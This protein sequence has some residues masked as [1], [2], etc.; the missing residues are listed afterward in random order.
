MITHMPDPAGRK[1]TV[2]CDSLHLEVGEWPEATMFCGGLGI[3]LGLY[4]QSREV[5]VTM[6]D[7][8]EHAKHA[9]PANLALANSSDLVGEYLSDVA[10]S[11][12]TSIRVA[13]DASWFL[14]TSLRQQQQANSRTNL[15]SSGALEAKVV[16]D[17][18]QSHSSPYPI[19]FQCAFE[20][21]KLSLSATF[22]EGSHG[23]KFVQRLLGQISHVTSQL[24]L[25]NTVLRDLN[26]L[27]SEDEQDIR[28]WT[29]APALMSPSCV[30]LLVDKQ[31]VKS[32]NAAAVHAWDGKLTYGELDELSS[33][34]AVQ[35]LAAKAPRR[36]VIPLLLEKSMWTVVA[37][38]AVLKSGHAFLL[39]DASHPTG[40]LE[41]LIHDIKG[42][43]IMASQ[44]QKDRASL[45]VSRV[46][47]VSSTTV[48]RDT[49]VSPWDPV[50]AVTGPNDLALVVYT[51]GTT[52]RPKATAIEHHSICSGLM[53]LAEL[54]GISETCRYYQFSSY[55]WDAAFGEILMTLFSGGCVCIPS[56][57]DRINRLA[58]SMNLLNANSVLLTPTVLRLLSPEEI[59]NMKNIIMG[60]E[61]VTRGL[62]R[63]WAGHAS[64][65]TVY[66]PAECTVACM[67]NQQF[68]EEFDPALIG[69]S[70]GCR[71]WITLA[72]DIN[73]LAPVGVAGELLIEGS[74][75]ARGYLNDSEKTAK[76]FLT[77]PPAWMTKMGLNRL[78]NS[79]FYRT[80]DLARYTTDG[81]LIFVGR[82]DF[83]VKL[84]GQRIE[85]EEIQSQI[86]RLLGL[87]GAQVF[88]DVV[89]V[90]GDQQLPSLAAFIHLPEYQNEAHDGDSL[91]EH[92]TSECERLRVTLSEVLPEFMVP[93]VWIPLPSIPL[94]SSGKL[95]RR[96]LL[97]LGN[98]Y[99]SDLQSAPRETDELNDMQQRL[100]QLWAQI[101]STRRPGLTDN[102][103]SLG[104]DSV[105]A[106]RLVASA[107]H[108]KIELS[109]K[110]I[111]RHPTLSAMSSTAK[112]ITHSTGPKRS[113]AFSMLLED[114]LSKSSDYLK[115]L[116][117]G[118][119]DIVD[120]FP[121][122][123]L[124][125]SMFS[126]S[127]SVPG[128]Y[129]SQYVFPLHSDGI[130]EKVKRALEHTVAAIPILRA[131][132]LLGQVGFNQ[133][134]LR[135]SLQWTAAQQPL[136]AF[137]ESDRR[138]IF[139]IGEPLTR[140]TIVEDLVS[141]QVNFVWTLHHSTFD[142]W[143]IENIFARIRSQ[144]KERSTEEEQVDGDFAK[145]VLFSRN[146][147]S[148]DA[149]TFWRKQL[150][151]API[152]SFPTIP[153][154]TTQ[155]A[156]RSCITHFMDASKFAK[157]GVTATILA[158]AGLGLLLS[159]YENSEHIVFGNTLH[160]RSSLPSE[161]HSV[162]GPTLATLPVR[163]K[164]D[165]Q[166]TVSQFLTN[167]QD[168]FIATIPYEQ[169]GL[170]RIR[171]I[172][173]D[174]RASAAFRV[175]LIVQNPD[176][177]PSIGDN[178]EGR[179]AFRCLHEYPLVITITPQ[180]TRVKMYWTFDETCLS[181]DQVRPLASQFEQALTQLCS[182]PDSTRLCDL[183][184]ASKCDK[185][186]FFD[187]NSVHHKQVDTSAVDLLRRQ[188]ERDPCA[189]A[190]DA[191]D[192]TLSYEALDKI[193]DTFAAELV[194]LGV[195]PNTLVGHCF[196][197]SMW[198]PVALI[199]VLKSGG[200]FAPFSPVYPRE[201]L[202]AFTRDAGIRLIVCSRQQRSSLLDGP[203]EILVADG[204]SLGSLRPNPEI[205]LPAS[206]SPRS[207]IYALQTSGTTG[208]PKTFTVRHAAFA[209]GTVTRSS[210]IPRGSGM[211]V[212]QFGPYTFRLG[213]ENILA[214]LTAGGCLCIPS[215]S[216]MMNNLSGYMREVRVN[217]ANVTPSVARTLVPR[218][219]P[220]LKVLLVSGEPPDRD[221][222]SNW[223]GRVQLVNGYGPSEFTAKQTLNFAMTKDDPQNLGRAVG[224]SLWVV[225][226]E[227]YERL[228]PLGAVGE[229]LIEGPTLADGYINRPSEMEKWF[230]STPTWLQAFRG[231]PTIVFRSGDLVGYNPDGSLTSV[232]RADGQVKLH[233]QRFE[234]KE[235]EHQIRECLSDGN[236]DVLVDVLKFKGHESE[237]VVA[238]VT[239]KDHELGSVLEL[240]SALGKRVQGKK[241]KVTEYLS[242]FLP[243][244]MIPSVFLGVSIIPVT[245]NG[246]A[247]RR[248]L[249]AFG[250]QLP[251]SS[252]SAEAD[253]KMVIPPISDEEKTLHGLWQKVLGLHPAQFGLD[254]HFFELGG[255]SMTAIRLV[256]IARE[257]EVT[258][259][260]HSI[261][262]YPVL[263]DMALQLDMRNANLTPMPVPRFSLLQDIDCS[264]EELNKELSVHGVTENDI[265][266]AYP[267]LD[268]QGFY[269]KKAVV[270][271]GSTTYQHVYELQGSIDLRKLE[272]ALECVWNA[273][274]SLRTRVVS[275]SGK[276]VQ[277]V[278]KEDLACSRLTRLESCFEKDRD[279]SWALGAP[280]SRFSIVFDEQNHRLPAYLVWSS[281]HVVWDQWSRILICDDIDYA[282]QHGSLPAVR[283]SYRDFIAH[284]CQQGLDAASLGSS[285]LRE[286]YLGRQFA[287]LSHLDWSKY[288]A[289]NSRRMTMVVE[290]PV[291][292]NLKILHS[293][294]LLSCWT[295]ALAA[296]EKSND[297][298]TVN[299]INGRGSPF[300]G[301]ESL[302]APVVGAIPLCVG[303][304]SRTIR[305]H[306]ALVQKHTIEGLSLQH[307]VAL[308]SQLL[309]QI[310][311]SVYWVLI[312]DQDGHE[313]PTTASLRLQR[314]RAE[315]IATGVWP[316]YLTFNVH[317]GNTKVELEAIFD[318][319]L[320]PFE[321]ALKFF[322][323][324]KFLL[325]SIFA[326]GGLDK[327]TMEMQLAMREMLQGAS[328]ILQEV[329]ANALVESRFRGSSFNPYS[330]NRAPDYA[331]EA[332]PKE[333][334]TL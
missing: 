130:I 201:R 56:E 165:R 263:R 240:D 15:R 44:A 287:S 328:G 6:Q 330:T 267:C 17:E 107:R 252:A 7:G 136:D 89:D 181:E 305:E 291:L 25:S 81:K 193:S 279:A 170:L 298:L 35:L 148:E 280:L 190:V 322:A 84:R 36:S 266:D 10:E 185:T 111:F 53:G 250:S 173:H 9:F 189:L 234:A 33:S 48:S 52:G 139:D 57:E 301:V 20:A 144:L 174:T 260:A 212:L 99:L 203:W 206:V 278:C 37:M 147:D 151:Q 142:G 4:E 176:S 120:I 290:L 172:D 249:K 308:Q 114:D 293:S 211:R 315:K 268:L 129:I 169:Y 296:V 97:Q 78:P 83:Q 124:Q 228:S 218:E 334:E 113:S 276:L 281:N 222:I 177:A 80:G 261:F 223:A 3:I 47:L 112:A 135:E 60:G 101:L 153:T 95:D 262:K 319:E 110:D 226:P 155:I 88:V 39:L 30:H 236:L 131:R 232:G 96:A 51:S 49:A 255:S 292:E 21:S 245:A 285:L 54:A 239:G 16:F 82:R 244:Y 216:T 208:Q 219:V 312:N 137:L 309:S 256:A 122:T 314:N 163:V 19:S 100:S 313:E 251:L 233:A 63:A 117:F 121:C 18:E 214:T 143:S 213:I 40:R 204:E 307:S 65:T 237:V 123:Q 242:R 310:E 127:L 326:P 8:E 225:D 13:A 248:A 159:Q 162:L 230:I 79:R 297:I 272:S 331:L 42:S 29:P 128:S 323:C 300:P 243:A 207:L 90:L 270:F 286:E 179:E 5:V 69:S 116:G 284:V 277:V 311:S 70:F 180:S 202:L 46:I 220:D 64:L 118:K 158:R 119:E 138:K 43:I 85:L 191:W 221:L 195:R 73:Q 98:S 152:P 55:A 217:F 161:L 317:P 321:K 247:D 134:I 146:M 154:D 325:G 253:P 299:E 68:G 75:V 283:P 329:R 209:T 171:D 197:K 168:Q 31:V 275:V 210:L 303:I 259:F 108:A 109:V 257:A 24:S 258:L 2:F 183:D 194:R 1:L 67:V 294:L 58:Q 74:N 238:F 61:K 23:E 269:M 215:D 241:L 77:A 320:I 302:A 12:R 125:E 306:A 246:K 132:F 295:L 224:A 175:L 178:I 254:D 264:L 105:K 145:F 104:G 184:L 45:L 196:E 198:A 271:P 318:V 192:G 282:Y 103:F 93:T 332:E 86:Q 50:Q 92:M 160:G 187:W 327:N 94:S 66:A 106:M 166:E 333:G 91:A 157:P 71:V 186:R 265:E 235:V 182:V 115:R 11:L 167:L 38:M 22:R 32:P 140:Y 316:F 289:E 274:P 199:A 28:Q 14:S 59:P 288:L 41:M 150:L 87:P 72:D 34:L 324:L 229:L 133:A 62:V 126:F 164:V 141:G 156:D 231:E 205:A 102:F 149:R 76:S 227:N 200:A 27:S 304:H 188:I 26:F 273:T